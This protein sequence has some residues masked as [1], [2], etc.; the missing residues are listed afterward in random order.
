VAVDLHTHSLYSDGTDDPAVLVSLALSSGLTTLA[1][2]DHDT[3]AG[4]P[5]AR[6]AAAGTGLGFIPGVEL[7]VD[8]EAGPAHFLAYWIE[9]GNGPLQDRL[10]ELAAGRARRNAEILAALA[11][12][13]FDLSPEE[14]RLGPGVAGRPHIAA[15][16]VRHGHV[17]TM[18]A[19]FDLYWPGVAP[20]TG[21]GC[22]SPPP[23]RS[24]GLGEPAARRCWPTPTPWGPAPRSTPP[25]CRLS[26]AWAER[27]SSAITPTTPRSSRPTWPR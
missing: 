25:R 2:T 15:A 23:M 3:L 11:G 7:S 9:P 4:I 17:P 6:A 24:P 12:L 1:L 10:A 20:P 5:A 18:E 21:T 16:L 19:A 26:P 22:A 8:W 27:E 13:G 14:L